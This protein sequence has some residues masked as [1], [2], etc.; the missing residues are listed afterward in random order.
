[1]STSSFTEFNLPRN[2]YAAFDAVSLKQLIRN[3]LKTMNVFPD[4]D[5]E[6][7]NINGLVDVVAYTYHVLL[8]YLNQ[9]ASDSL[10]SQAELFENMNKIISLIGY[11]PTGSHTAA[12]KVDMYGT[13]ALPIGTYTIPRFSYIIINNITYSFNKDIS[14]QKVTDSLSDELIDSVGQN[15]LMYQGTFKEYPEYTAIGENFEMFTLNVDYPLDLAPTKML[16]NDNIYVFVKDFNTEKWSE[17]KEINSLYL[18]DNISKVFEKR[19]N[20][21]GH[22]EIKFGDSINGK[23]LNTGDTVTIIYLESDS[24]AGLVGIGASKEGK[25]AAYNTLRFREILNHIQDENAT[26]LNRDN[27]L[28][29]K[30]DNLYASIPPTL[31]E[32]VGEIRKNAPL[33]FSAQNRAVTKYDYEVYIEK[34]F[35]NIIQSVKVVSNKE[36]TSEYIA[37]YYDLGLE[38]PNLD[39]KLLFNQVS[40]NDACDFNNVYL[41][42]VPRLGAIQNETTPIDLFFSQKQ[43]IVDRLEDYKMINHNIVVNDPIYVAFDV[44]LPV[45]EETINS[46]IRNETKIRVTR[47][48]NQVISK[49][50]I[51]NLIFN[52]IKDF[53][54]Q[55]NNTLG[56]FLDL[57]KLSFDILSIEGIKTLETVRVI[58]NVEYKTPQLSFVYWNPLYSTANVNT[59]SQNMNLKFYQFPFFYEIT[60]LINKI[61]VI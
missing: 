33:I 22:Y 30:F 43:A 5:Y 31:T 45:L 8:F 27:S 49:D 10:F 53:F 60:K 23:R 39:D 29:I 13:V 40:F 52:L 11:K 3:R 36:Y 19:L 4:I 25:L 20:E 28:S 2:A 37:Y 14:F 42:C 21:Y 55:E 16:D 6:G 24:S 48:S 35:S 46:S 61:E 54:A 12:L 26:Y 15:N 32:T 41:F 51:K 17:W 34:Y 1:M 44:G 9:T 58:D 59:T 18:A 57:T 38:R 7:S 50:Q 47:T 56:Q